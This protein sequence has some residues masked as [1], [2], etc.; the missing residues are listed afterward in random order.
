MT[1]MELRTSVLKDI[2][3]LLDNDS[4]MLQLQKFVRQLKR[5]TRAKK[6]KLAVAP[7]IYTV[8][9][10]KERLNRTEADALSGKGITTQEVMK[11]I[12]KWK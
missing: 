4:A 8:E 12:E 9:E 10:V 11:R 7:C 3:S 6:E 2:A 1:T 5:E